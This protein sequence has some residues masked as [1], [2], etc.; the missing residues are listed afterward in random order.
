MARMICNPADAERASERACRTRYTPGEI[1]KTDSNH[2]KAKVESSRRGQNNSSTAKRRQA[3]RQAGRRGRRGSSVEHIPCRPAA[4]EARQRIL[5]KYYL[6]HPP[7]RRKRTRTRRVRGRGGSA[8]AR[9]LVRAV[10]P[11][12]RGALCASVCSA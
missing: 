5:Q 3:S 4:A 12:R 6:L 1:K 11:N 2:K 9:F 8:R 10:S 7:E